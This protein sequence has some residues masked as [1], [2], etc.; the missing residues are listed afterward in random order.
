MRSTMTK[1]ELTRKKIY[2]VSIKLFNEKGYDNVSILEITKQCEISKGNFYTHFKSKSDILVEQFVLIDTIYQ[3]YYETNDSNGL[4]A[5]EKFLYKIFYVVE[6]YVGQEIL[7]VLYSEHLR[8]NGIKCLTSNDRG[9]YL[10]L[11]NILKDKEFENCNKDDL[12]M[13]CIL[14]IRGVCYEWSV[15]TDK[16]ILEFARG[17][18]NILITGLKHSL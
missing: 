8:V 15:S 7:K 16:E 6:N 13:A 14:L 11:N 1:G 4:E 5:L 12:L 10:V 18:I 17:S 9:L 3:E 2:D